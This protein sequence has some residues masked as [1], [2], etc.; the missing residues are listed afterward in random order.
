MYV[1]IKDHFT[2]VKESIDLYAVS[3]SHDTAT[4]MFRSKMDTLDRLLQQKEKKTQA[5]KKIKER[6]EK[7]EVKQ[8]RLQ[9]YNVATAERD[10]LNNLESGSNS[11]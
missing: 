2:N 8:V 6:E 11:L 1:T 10:S 7:K 9:T 5:I 3:T 4:Q